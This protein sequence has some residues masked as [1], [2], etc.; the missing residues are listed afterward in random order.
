MQSKRSQTQVTYCMIPFIRNIQ[1]W[2]IQRDRA[3]YRLAVVK[4]EREG[5]QN[6]SW[7]WGFFLVL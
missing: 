2:Q 5:K 7:V 4:G 3:A 1:N 6:A